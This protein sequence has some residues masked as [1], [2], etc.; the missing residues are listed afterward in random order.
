VGARLLGLRIQACRDAGRDQQAE[1]GGVIGWVLLYL[2]MLGFAIALW[3]QEDDPL[4]AYKR[5]RDDA[6][7]YDEPS[8]WERDYHDRWNPAGED[9]PGLDDWK[10]PRR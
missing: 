8:D 5:S 7:E 4:G 3:I 10:G 9:E 2:L 6:R 1:G